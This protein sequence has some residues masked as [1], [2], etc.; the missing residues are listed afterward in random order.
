MIWYDIPNFPGYKISHTGQVLSLK[1]SEPR[2]MK[3]YI[4]TTGYWSVFLRRDGKYVNCKIHILLMRTFHGPCPPGQNVCHNDGNKL[5]LSLSNLRY[6]SP[7]GNNLDQVNHGTHFEAN[8]DAC[9]QGHPFTPENTGW[10]W[11][12][13]GKAGGKKCRRCKECHRLAIAEQR[14]KKRRKENDLAS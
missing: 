8:R 3:Q 5:N 7:S 1:F 9:D 2:I 6:D 11:G 12:R 13:G 10:R 14:A 4:S